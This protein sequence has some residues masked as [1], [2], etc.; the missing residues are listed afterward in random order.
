MPRLKLYSA[1]GTLLSIHQNPSSFVLCADDPIYT[2]ERENYLSVNGIPSTPRGSSL[3]SLVLAIWNFMRL[4]EVIRRIRSTKRSLVK[5]EIGKFSMFLGIRS[6]TCRCSECFC[7]FCGSLARPNDDCFRCR[8]RKSC[9][10][11]ICVT[12]EIIIRWPL[13]SVLSLPLEF[14][15]ERFLNRPRL[16]VS[17][18]RVS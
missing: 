2:R 8:S 6:C 3:W 9:S 5:P 11:L 10:F 12:T 14:A 7:G 4:K 1:Y 13:T 17:P 16:L 18:K 15:S